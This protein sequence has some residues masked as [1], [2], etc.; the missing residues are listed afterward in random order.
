[1]WLLV[2]KPFHLGDDVHTIDAAVGPEVQKDEIPAHLLKGVAS[3]RIQ[4]FQVLGQ[5]GA[6]I[7]KLLS[8]FIFIT[9]SEASTW[10]N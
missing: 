7:Q 3:I 6:N 10:P 4:P 9:C 1:M 8:M 2:L 5:L